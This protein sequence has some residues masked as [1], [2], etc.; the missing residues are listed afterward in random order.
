MFSLS[1]S[2]SPN[3]SQAN[4]LTEELRLLKE[5]REEQLRLEHAARSE[6][7]QATTAAATAHAAALQEANQRASAAEQERQRLAQRV[8]ALERLGRGKAAAEMA[9]LTQ[10]RQHAEQQLQQTEARR[11]SL[12]SENIRL[13]A[14]LKRSQRTSDAAETSASGAAANL[15]SY[16]ADLEERISTDSESRLRS[17]GSTAELLEFER[18]RGEL[19]RRIL[20]DALTSSHDMPEERL[21]DASRHEFMGRTRLVC[22][23][24]IKRGVAAKG[25]QALS[26]SMCISHPSGA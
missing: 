14:E 25:L 15:A 12:N 23:G 3:P 7:E 24:C 1:P 8:A 22:I 16:R 10:R 4:E 2:Q 11:S 19:E 20:V 6:A 13:R 21:Y 26:M 17:A 9:E 18:R 5:E